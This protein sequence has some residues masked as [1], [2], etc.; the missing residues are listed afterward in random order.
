MA[1]QKG[2]KQKPLLPEPEKKAP[3]PRITTLAHEWQAVIERY[4]APG[5]PDVVI[6]VSLEDKIEE[7]LG[8]VHT[9]F[10]P[11]D[12]A[13]FKVQD[14]RGCHW[15]TVR[16]WENK[17]VK[18]PTMVKARQVALSMGYDIQFVKIGKK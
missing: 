4:N 6:E 17:T 7:L 9:E 13:Y 3:L 18:R 5:S 10:G 14:R 8:I 15:T 1:N 12:D 2:L 16:N 11:G